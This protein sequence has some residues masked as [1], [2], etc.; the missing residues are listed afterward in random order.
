MSIEV[1]SLSVLTISGMSVVFMINKLTICECHR[2]ETIN[3]YVE[4]MP[5]C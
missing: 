3:R 2:A 1:G 4:H 5:L